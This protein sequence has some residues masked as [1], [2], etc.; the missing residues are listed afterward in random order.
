MPLLPNH[1]A[2][3]LDVAKLRD[4]CLSS[5]HLRGRHKARVFAAALGISAADAHW[6]RG[7]ILVALGSHDAVKEDSDGFGERWRVDLLLTRQNRR[8]MVRTHW[9]IPADTGIPRLVT[10]WVL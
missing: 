1:S 7:A 6:L 8:A 9:L 2:A 10:A 3:D 5:A 4:Y